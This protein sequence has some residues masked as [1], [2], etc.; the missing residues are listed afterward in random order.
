V[1]EFEQALSSPI[2]SR[3]LKV[4]KKPGAILAQGEAILEL[5]VSTA[6][7]NLDK[8]NDQIALK[9]NQQAQ[10]RLDLEKNLSDLQTQ[11][12][13]KKL[14]REYLQAKTEEQK[15]LFAIGGSS[16]QQMRQSELEEEIAELELQQ[17]DSNIHNT[18]N[19]LQNQ[20]QGVATEI[21]ILQKERAEAQHELELATAKAPRPGVLTFA[22]SEEGATVRPGEVIARIADLSSFRVQATVSDVHASRLSLNLPVKVKI[23]EEYLQGSV[24]SIYPKIENGVITLNVNLED[25]SNPALRSNLRVDVFIVTA[26]RE[27]VLRV[28]KGAY[29]TGEGTQEVFVL[30]DGVAHKTRV[31]FGLTSFEYFEAVEG[32]SEGDEVIISDMR[33]FLH[34]NEVRV[35]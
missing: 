21:R 5:D 4:L 3:V 15:Q 12:R 13:I 10:L 1:P 24:A 29:V 34:V 16:K 6:Q 35:D 17:L 2:D 30:R 8:L 26:S 18:Q 27:Q 31:R 28:K 11:A 23:N 9:E 25:K 14:R 33:D 22:L 20:L 19:S 32:L 7:L